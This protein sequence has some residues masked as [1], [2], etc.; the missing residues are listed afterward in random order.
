MFDSLN[1]AMKMR[2]ADYDGT[3]F[4]GTVVNNADPLNIDR[5]QVSIPN[6]YDESLGDL[7]WIGPIKDSPFGIGE[8]WGVFGTP[9]IGST[10]AILF[11]SGDP[12]YPV[13]VGGV[14]S[15]AVAGFV[16]GTNWGFKDP[17]GNTLNINL[18]TEVTTLTLASGF[19]IN[20]DAAGNAKVTTPG[21][22]TRS[23]S[24][25]IQDSTPG[26]ATLTAG[27]YVINGSTRVNGNMSVSTGAT[28][29]FTTNSGTV[30]TV[31]DG[32][33]INIQ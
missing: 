2:S 19:T 26:T 10:V 27:N 7:P 30:V 28:G 31:Q 33:V 1:E 15:T 32:I 12:H 4:K 18:A 20:I 23:V 24:G 17:A 9:A 25:S 8:T 6:L 5:I 21:S 16:S 13:Y 3:Y 22:Y 11:Q 29:T 14:Q